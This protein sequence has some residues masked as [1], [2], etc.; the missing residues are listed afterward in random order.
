MDTPSTLTVRHQVLEDHMHQRRSQRQN[1]VNIVLA[2]VR[3]AGEGLVADGKTALF[4]PKVEND[5]HLQ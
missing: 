2:V 5:C 4:V 3:E 1:L